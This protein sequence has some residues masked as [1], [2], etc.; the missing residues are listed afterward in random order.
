MVDIRFGWAVGDSL[1]AGAKRR[2]KDAPRELFCLFSRQ[3][4]LELQRARRFDGAG[5]IN[6]GP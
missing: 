3:N 1:I 2:W 4:T 6:T 5:H